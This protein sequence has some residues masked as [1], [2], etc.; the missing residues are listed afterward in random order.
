M[1]FQIEVGAAVRTVKV[2]RDG[3]LFRVIVDGRAH[4]VDVRRIDGETL[5]LLVQPNG[6]AGGARSIEAAIVAGREAGA[7]DVHVA[8]HSVPVQLRTGSV[9]RR[10]RDRATQGTGPQ[11][12]LAPMPGKIVRVLVKPGDTVK[13]RQGLVV[14]EAMKMENELKAARDGHVREV[15]VAEGQSVEAG[16][17]LVI[18]E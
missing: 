7:F 11:R 17:A 2:E 15:S 8:G 9:S 1:Q 16:A 10:G 12:V 5:S 4:L 6:S 13:A 14:V 3:E 18:V